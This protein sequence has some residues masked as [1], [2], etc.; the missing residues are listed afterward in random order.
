MDAST[1]LRDRATAGVVWSALH[2]WGT[3]AIQL[4]VMLVLARLLEPR[5][6]GLF[7][8]A[9]VVL[10]LVQPLGVQG[11]PDALVQ[12]DRDDP[13]DWS[14]GFVAV[15][16]ASTIIALLLLTGAPLLAVLLGSPALEPILRG[17]APAV[18]LSGVHGIWYGRVRAGLAFF[19]YAIAGIVA[20]VAA[21]VVAVPIAMMGGGV[22]ALVASLYVGLGVET[23]L[24]ARATDWLPRMLFHREAYRRLLRFGRFIV[25]GEFTTF[26]NRRTDDYFIG[27]Y[28]GAEVLGYYVIA[29]RL[30]ELAT[31]VFL[32][33]VENV[34]FPVFAKL[35]STPALVAEAVRTTFRFTGM[36][37]FPA[38]AGL[39][40]V[41]PDLV[42]VAL[43]E[44]WAPGA[45]ALRIL[46]LAGFA[47]SASNVLPSA[48]RAAGRPQWNV[49]ISAVKGVVLAAAFAVAA[50]W[51]IQAVAWVFTVGVYVAFPA[52]FVAVRRLAPLRLGE[53]LG[54]GLRPFLATLAMAGALLATW[55]VL[56]PLSP[57]AR[58]VLQVVLGVAVYA[59]AL[60]AVGATHLR[61]LAARLRGLRGAG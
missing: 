27:L 16:G 55:P 10:A 58:L 22:W 4:G 17:L 13:R 20:A 3:R 38:F 49:A 57:V 60:R 47:L 44:R 9:Q 15:L 1:S 51:S 19:D 24:L 53:Y 23:A 7:A 18:A 48:I 28:L 50:R 5:D 30:L 11:I 39:V 2:T 41:A 31:T 32:R 25:A 12:A 61:E 52:F 35:Q 6:F 8:L 43:G 34:A 46:A 54:E 29:Y 59:L 26:L 42:A 45:P 36:V 33:A 37:S 21:F 14:T 40:F 56:A